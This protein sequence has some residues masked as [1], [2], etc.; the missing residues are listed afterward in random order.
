LSPTLGKSIAMAMVQS[1]H[2]AEGTKL[3]VDFGRQQLTAKVVKVPFYK[4]PK[5]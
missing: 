4:K 5:K 2:A 1:E 3:Q